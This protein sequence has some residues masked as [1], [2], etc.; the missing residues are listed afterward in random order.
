MAPLI[1]DPVHAPM[2]V[3]ADGFGV[4]MA[5]FTL[6]ASAYRDFVLLERPKLLD[7]PPDHWFDKQR[8]HKAVGAGTRY[9]A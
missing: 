7:P 2:F 6:V 4:P 1:Y 3:P 9:C 8:C 5:P